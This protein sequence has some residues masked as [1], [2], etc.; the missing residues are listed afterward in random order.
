MTF[1]P[2][3]NNDFPTDQTFHQFHDLY[4]ELGLNRIMSGF[5]GAFATG[6]ASQRERL[7]FRT[8]ISVPLFG[9]YLCYNC[10][11][12]IPR[13]CHVSTRRFALN[14]PW[15]FL[16]FALCICKFCLVLTPKAKSL[17]RN[18]V[19]KNVCFK[20]NQHNPH[21]RPVWWCTWCRRVWSRFIITKSTVAL[22]WKHSNKNAWD[23]C[24][25]L[26]VNS[27]N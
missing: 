1:W 15:Y 7:P 4:T 18:V 13:T 10:W 25:L 23:I 17:T 6:V 20:L 14:T 3:T 11:D 9:T 27:I 19:S 5:H 8:P 12:Q 16:E 24:V 2:L 21:D 26:S 22:T